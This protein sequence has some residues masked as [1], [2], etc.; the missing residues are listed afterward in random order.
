MFRFL[1][2]FLRNILKNNRIFFSEI[3]IG[4]TILMNQEI[5][6]IKF[7][8]AL[9]IPSLI[10]GFCSDNEDEPLNNLEDLGAALPIVYNQSQEYQRH[11]AVSEKFFR[12]LSKNPEARNIITDFKNEITN[13]PEAGLTRIILDG[14]SSRTRILILREITAAVRG[15]N[16]NIPFRLHNQDFSL[17]LIPSRRQPGNGILSRVVVDDNNNAVNG[18][19]EQIYN[20]LDIY[21]N[22]YQRRITR[23]LYNARQIP[24]N[25]VIFARDYHLNMQNQT[26]IR[27][28]AK[29]LNLEMLNLLLDFEVA[30]RLQGTEDDENNS[31]FFQEVVDV[32]HA[33]HAAHVD[34]VADIQAST[35]VNNAADPNVYASTDKE[36]FDR[37]PIASAIVGILKIPTGDEDTRIPLQRFFYAPENDEYGT[38]GRYCAFQGYARQAL[39]ANSGK[40]IRATERII[41]L[42]RGG[43]NA[44]HSTNQQ[45]HEEYLDIFGGESESDGDDY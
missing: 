19:H 30:R 11:Q 25:H 31:A 6:M 8:L 34:F 10:I 38:W 17:N 3:I 20:I 12:R 15:E 26:R 40:R 16:T 36:E 32:N 1:C 2:D 7:F 44:V 5:Q 21:K 24:D 4:V 43:E 33:Q 41:R 9:A 14:F 27:A 39:N 23:R 18:T 29:T 22:S 37:I 28:E 35:V 13:P 42:L 45:I